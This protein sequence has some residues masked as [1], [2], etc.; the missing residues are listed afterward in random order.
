MS[1]IKTIQTVTVDENQ[2]QVLCSLAN[3]RI[4]QF[5]CDLDI[6]N[7]VREDPTNF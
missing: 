7:R 5:N 2:D 4:L 3:G 1:A 6:A